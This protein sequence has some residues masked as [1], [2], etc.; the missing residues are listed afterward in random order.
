MQVFPALSQ[1]GNPHYSNRSLCFGLKRRS[2]RTHASIRGAYGNRG[3]AAREICDD[4]EACE[5]CDDEGPLWRLSFSYFIPRR[6]QLDENIGRNDLCCHAP[7]VRRTCGGDG[8]KRFRQSCLSLSPLR[9]RRTVFRFPRSAP[10]SPPGRRPGTGRRL[11]RRRA[12][13]WNRSASPGRAP[14]PD[15]GSPSPA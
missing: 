4:E 12:A 1:T 5:I 11:R 15:R 7:S 10:R 9:S 8:E 6:R 2:N 3:C 14:E 13:E